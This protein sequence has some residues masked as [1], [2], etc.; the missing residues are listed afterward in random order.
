MVWSTT[1]ALAS[2]LLNTCLSLVARL[3]SATLA[4][5]STTSLTTS[6]ANFAFVLSGLSGVSSLSTSSSSRPTASPS[7]DY[8]TASAGAHPNVRQGWADKSW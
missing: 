6:L 7:M 2:S 8:T 3:G 5:S 4:T 1:S